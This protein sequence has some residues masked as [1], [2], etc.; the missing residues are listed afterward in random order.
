MSVFRSRNR[1]AE[2]LDAEIATHLEMA[3]RER[4]AAG[5]SPEAARAEALREFG[6]VQQIKHTTREMWGGNVF[7]DLKHD[8]KY[9]FRALN[10]SRSFALTAIATLA[11]GISAATVIFSVADHVVLRPLAYPDSKR[12][13]VIQEQIREMRD[14]FPH[15]SRQRQPLPGV[16]ATVQGM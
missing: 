12:L 1:R 6:N 5:A 16:A 9:A 8:V 11:V 14:E 3:V 10:R 13:F 2:E 15:Y 4:I 7:D